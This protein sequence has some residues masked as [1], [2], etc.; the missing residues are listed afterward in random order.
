VVPRRSVKRQSR[1][2]FRMGFLR[3]RADRAETPVRDCSTTYP[4]LERELGRL[5][6]R[7]LE[8]VGGR[9][10][11]LAGGVESHAGAGQG[12]CLDGGMADDAGEDE[13]RSVE[14]QVTVPNLCDDC[15][16]GGAVLR[17]GRKT[18]FGAG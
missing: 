14:G 8:K 5:P 17:D 1:T 2:S 7:S 11:L 13:G 18:G 12:L 15:R 10:A 6:A 4:L 3:Q 16:V 9:A